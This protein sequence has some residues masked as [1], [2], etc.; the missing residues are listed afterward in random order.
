MLIL[1]DE[2]TCVI[3]EVLGGDHDDIHQRADAEAARGEQPEDARADL[4]RVEAVDAEIAKED[5]E[6][7][8]HEPILVG[9][10]PA[11]D[12]VCAL[13]LCRAFAALAARVAEFAG[14]NRPPAVGTVFGFHVVF[15]L[16][17]IARVR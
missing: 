11:L 1:H 12:A 2:P 15:P 5:R 9:I 7:Q 3:R 8:R 17:D 16:I 4:A 13:C 10:L 6:Q 14:L